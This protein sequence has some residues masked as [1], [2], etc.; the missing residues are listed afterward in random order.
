MFLRFYFIS[1]FVVCLRRIFLNTSECQFAL[2]IHINYDEIRFIAN[3]PKDDITWII[4]LT[5]HRIA[6]TFGYLSNNLE[7]RKLILNLISKELLSLQPKGNVI[8]SGRHYTKTRTTL[9]CNTV[10]S[11]LAWIICKIKN[12]YGYVWF[13]FY[14]SW[15]TTFEIISLQTGFN[16]MTK[17]DITPSI[18]NPCLSFLLG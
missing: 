2:D 11:Y 3:I 5:R 10:R 13:Q 15:H 4:L 18:I 8:K 9:L 14:R 16:S 1:L 6:L 7:F 17:Q 12:A